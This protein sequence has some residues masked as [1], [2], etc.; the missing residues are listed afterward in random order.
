MSLEK[1]SQVIIF[2][3][4]R[5][6]LIFPLVQ[7]LIINCRTKKRSV[8]SVDIIRRTE[9]FDAIYWYIVACLLR[10]L[11]FVGRKQLGI[12]ITCQLLP[13]AVD[14]RKLL[15]LRVNKR[16]FQQSASVRGNV[17]SESIYSDVITNKVLIREISELL[18]ACIFIQFKEADIN[19]AE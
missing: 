7:I 13:Y 14:G 19:R 10:L 18:V 2:H 5:I 4:S 1:S 9:N 12:L 11:F 16:R 3:F 15:F 17:L 6:S 8:N